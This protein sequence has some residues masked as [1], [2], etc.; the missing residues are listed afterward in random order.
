MVLRLALFILGAVFIAHG[1]TA[2][3]PQH[4]REAALKETAVAERISDVRSGI[5][6]ILEDWP[7]DLNEQYKI[8]DVV[9]AMLPENYQ[10]K[11][12]SILNTATDTRQALIDIEQGWLLNIENAAL[13]QAETH[14]NNYLAAK[15]KNERSWESAKEIA[16]GILSIAGALL[17]LKL[18]NTSQALTQVVTGVEDFR[19]NATPGTWE[20]VSAPLATTTDQST[21]ARI[22]RIRAKIKTG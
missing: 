22:E 10:S 20:K 12:T 13:D 15:D 5:R 14:M 2:C 21:K 11:A 19:K 16:L 9:I 8:I 4:E 1:L 7:D 17:G 6:N 18:K 3:T